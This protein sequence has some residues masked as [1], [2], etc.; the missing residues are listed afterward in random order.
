MDIDSEEEFRSSFPKNRNSSN[1]RVKGGDLR[2]DVSGLSEKEGA[3]VLDAWKIKRKAF[4]DKVHRT[5]IKADLEMRRFEFDIRENAL[6]NHN[7][8][9]RAMSVVNAS[10]LS[11]GHVFQLKNTLLLWIVEEANLRRV[12][13]KVMRSDDENLVVAG[14]HFYVYRRYSKKVGWSVVQ[15]CCREG[16]DLLMIPVKCMNISESKLRTPLRSKMIAPIIVNAIEETPGISYQMMTEILKPYAN[17]YAITLR[18]ITQGSIKCIVLSVRNSTTT[19]RTVLK[20][21]WR[22]YRVAST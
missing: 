3:E 13:I 14:F 22:D 4:T 9:L 17:N 15:A 6:G 10:Q 8:Q 18:K 19:Q 20:T 7:T 16:D 5:A 12:K 1:L 2:P 21:K 11:A